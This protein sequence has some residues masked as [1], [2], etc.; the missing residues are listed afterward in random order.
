M[1]SEVMA[2]NKYANYSVSKTAVTVNLVAVG[3]IWLYRVTQR[4]KP[5]P[6]YQKLVLN[7]IKAC[8]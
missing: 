7:R 5:L 6:N 4:S 2:S 3:E 8:R 1:A